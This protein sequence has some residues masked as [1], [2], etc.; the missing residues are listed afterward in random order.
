M[1][2]NYECVLMMSPS[3]DDEA[4][5]NYAQ[6]FSELVTQNEGEMLHMQMWGRRRLEY[7]IGGETDAIYAILHFRMETAG[8]LVE[9][10]ER[11]VRINDD[12][13]REMTVKVPELKIVESQPK[14]WRELRREP[15]PGRGGRPT[16]RRPSTR[17][18]PSPSPAPE[19]D[20]A[21]PPETSEATAATA[22]EE[23][24]AMP[25]EAAE[26]GPA[27]DSVESKPSDS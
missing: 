5:A 27:A 14:L 23:P 19:A 6:Q 13:L 12:L 2:Q 18:A 9:E 15:R 11:R 22:T 16:S 17:P 24:K 20:E 26:P 7:P 25:V 21:K 8:G 3:L 1:A 10:F 4:A